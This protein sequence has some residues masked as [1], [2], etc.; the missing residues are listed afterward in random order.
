M[1]IQNFLQNFQDIF[2]I[3]C[4]NLLNFSQKFHYYFQ[5]VLQIFNIIQ[6]LFKRRFI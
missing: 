5:N 6:I 3:H 4:I 2:N 1:I